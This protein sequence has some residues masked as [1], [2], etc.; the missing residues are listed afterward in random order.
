MTTGDVTKSVL[1]GFV[2]GFLGGIATEFKNKLKDESCQDRSEMKKNVENILRKAKHLWHH[3][4]GDRTI[5]PLKNIYQGGGN[6]D[7]SMLETICQDL[8]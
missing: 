7:Y 8:S 1:F 3:I 5:R 4:T 2:D 6:A